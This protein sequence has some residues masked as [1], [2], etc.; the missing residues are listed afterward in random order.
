MS[1]TYEQ[2]RAA[3][4][5]SPELILLAQEGKTQAIAD[6]ISVNRKKTVPTEVGNGTILEV[7][8]LSVGHALLDV[9]N[10][11]PDFRHVKPLVEQGRLRLDSP[12]TIQALQSLVPSVLTETQAQALISRATVDD[13]VTH[14]QVGIALSGANE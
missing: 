6:A 1:L 10:T 13:K 4:A 12:L 7:L 3:I 8:G 11:V 9:I 14:T 5:A 2:I